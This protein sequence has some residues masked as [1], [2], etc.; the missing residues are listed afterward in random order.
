MNEEGENEG[1]ETAEIKEEEKSKRNGK[2]DK[3]ENKWEIEREIEQEKGEIK[4]C[5]SCGRVMKSPEDHGGGN[6]NNP[7]CSDCTDEE[8][9]LYPR[10]VVEKNLI[11]YY[12]RVKQCSW[13]EAETVV[14]EI[15]KRMPAW[16]NKE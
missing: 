5:Q 1:N 15:L 10:E 14:K 11:D 8:G 13:E 16:K 12:L 2:R 4:I 7:Y 3:E 6:V 9:N